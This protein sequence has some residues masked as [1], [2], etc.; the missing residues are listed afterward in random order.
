MAHSA[1]ESNEQQI[2]ISYQWDSQEMCIRIKNELEKR[3]NR[4]V[5]IDIENMYGDTLDVMAKAVEQ[6]SCVLICMSEKYASSRNCE[7]EAKY[8]DKLNKPFVPLI[9]QNGYK[10]SGWYKIYL[11]IFFILNKLN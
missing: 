10:P 8:V 1:R 4:K 5:W 3:L 6:A 7:K 2:M 9:M 11:F